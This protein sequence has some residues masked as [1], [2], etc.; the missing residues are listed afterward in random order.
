VQ[1]T[2][3]AAVRHKAAG[4]DCTRI[5]GLIETP[6]SYVTNLEELVELCVSVERNL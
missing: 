5:C 6:R 1:N 2:A 4:L 3:V